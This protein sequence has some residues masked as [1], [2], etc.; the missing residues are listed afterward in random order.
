MGSSGAS[1][2]LTSLGLST[3]RVPLIASIGSQLVPPAGMGSSA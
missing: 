2:A 1:Q 3:Q